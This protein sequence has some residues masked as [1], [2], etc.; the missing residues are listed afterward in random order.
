MGDI[1]IKTNIEI[2]ISLVKE[3]FFEHG[4]KEFCLCPGS[5]NASLVKVLSSSS[6]L[7]IYSFFEERSAGY[8]A[9]GR[10]QATRLPVA[11]VTT[12]GTAAA[13][14][15]PSMIEAFYSGLPLIAITADRPKN[16]RGSGAPQTIDQISIFSSYVNLQCDDDARKESYCLANWQP[17]GP[18]HI[19]LCFDEPLID[20]EFIPLNFETEASTSKPRHPDIF[21]TGYREQDE[22]SSLLSKVDLSIQKFLSQV[23][24]PLV[25]LG[26]IPTAFRD[27]LRTF[28]LQIK[29]PIYAEAIS[30]FRE[31]LGG[32]RELSILLLRGGSYV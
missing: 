1:T 23:K 5:R 22:I 15:L 16:Y 25:I 30:G 10:I 14:L 2:S 21:E 17:C 13:N 12:S 32:N 3:L 27:A 28:L 29:R 19:N 11:V 18:A 31:V 20:A 8:F 24:R 26:S 7:R 9:L 4:V 6:G